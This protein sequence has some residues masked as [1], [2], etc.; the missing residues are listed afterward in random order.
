MANQQNRSLRS[1]IDEFKY[2]PGI[3]SKSDIRNAL[4]VVAALIAAVTF[5]AGLNPPGGVWQDNYPTPTPTPTQDNSPTPAQESRL[6]QSHKAGRAILGS[7]KASFTIFL[8]S[9]TVALSASIWVIGYLVQGFPFQIIVRIA[10]IFMAITYC[11]S[12]AAVQPEGF[13]NFLTLYIAY[14]APVILATAK[15]I[16]RKIKAL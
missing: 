4:L 9:N 12:I 14:F 3:D 15:D 11:A 5:Q 2:K 6:T 13:N 10:L 16:W 1:E 7:N 8:F